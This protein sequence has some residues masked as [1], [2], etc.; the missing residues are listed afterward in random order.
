[1]GWGSAVLDPD[2]YCILL[3]NIFRKLSCAHIKEKKPTQ[4]QFVS[5]FRGGDMA[6][7]LE[8]TTRLIELNPI[9]AIPAHGGICRTPLQLLH[10]YIEHRLQRY[11]LYALCKKMMT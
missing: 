6:V 1:M 5:L 9:L 8:S 3:S 11:V 2:A 4:Q 7:Y 10:Q